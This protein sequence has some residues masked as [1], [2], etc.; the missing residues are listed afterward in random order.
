L[1]VPDDTCVNF[2]Q[3]YKSHVVTDVILDGLVLM[4]P[5]YP[6]WHLNMP[7]RQKITV[8]GIFLLGGFVVVSG[9]LRVIAMFD[10]MIPDP[11]RTYARAPA[12][13]WATIET[14]TG[15][16]SACLPTMRPL[17]SRSGPESMIRSVQRRVMG[18]F[19]RTKLTQD[20]YTMG[21]FSRE[22]SG[23]SNGEKMHIYEGPSVDSYQQSTKI[24]ASEI[25]HPQS[26]T[27][28]RVESSVSHNSQKKT[29][30]F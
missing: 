5:W 18:S 29:S 4:I 28:I 9:I 2:Y 21:N 13:Y 24:E 23:E 15:I 1:P 11:D 3:L 12:F 22:P 16:V 20:D 14:G 30:S 7:A 10:A 19:S 26:H 25:E 8:C 17:V 27:G 6:V